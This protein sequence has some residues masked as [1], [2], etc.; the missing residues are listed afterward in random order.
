MDGVFGVRRDNPPT[1]REHFKHMQ[2]R[3]ELQYPWLE[4]E[5]AHDWKEL[6]DQWY[7]PC[8]SR[9]GCD[10]PAELLLDDVQGLRALLADATLHRSL[11]MTRTDFDA[12]RE[13]FASFAEEFLASCSCMFASMRIPWFSP[14][15]HLKPRR[16]ITER[17]TFDLD[18]CVVGD[19]GIGL[20]CY[21]KGAVA[22]AFVA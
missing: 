12:R 3:D 1:I 7:A 5:L 11:N 2:T 15:F 4:R 14:F 17:S 8:R 13:A 16:R 9:A 6:L 10:G 22:A 18:N 21:D 20:S 19:C